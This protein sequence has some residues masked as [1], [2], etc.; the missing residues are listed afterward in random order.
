MPDRSTMRVLRDQPFERVPMIQ[1]S[2]FTL[3]IGDKNLSSWSLRPWLAL[4]MGGFAFEEILIRLDRAETQAAIREH[5]PTGLVPALKTGGQV[6]WESLAILEYLNDRKPEAGLWPNDPARRA[7]A[8]CV[9]TEMHGGFPA[10]RLALPMAFAE[11]GLSADVTPQVE[12]DIARIKTLWSKALAAHNAE[13]PFL[14]GAF[15]AADAMY[16]PVVSRFRSYGVALTP[17]EQ[18]YCDAV[19][20]LDPMQEWLEGARAERAAD[21]RL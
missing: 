3:V 6:I 17:D 10:L 21:G 16:A 19:W 11:T 5:S 13:G 20:T 4:K 8:R 15:T 18:A 9:A 2:D 14:F 7:W 1:G 12:A